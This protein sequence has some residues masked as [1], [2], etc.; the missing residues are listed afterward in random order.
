M[1]S[2]QL[3]GETDRVVIAQCTDS[4]RDE[5]APAGD[6]YDESAYFRRQR[7]YAQVRGDLWFIQSAKHGL[8]D[9]DKEIAPYDKHAKDID[10]PE[11][12]AESIA[13][14][15]QKRVPPGAVVEILGGKDYADPLTPELERRGYDVHEPLRGLGIGKR[16]SELK[17]RTQEVSHE[18][19]HG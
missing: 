19:L 18:S 4:K 3:E 13:D 5:P 16:Q 6:I 12:W 15:L 10:K 17:T 11:S 1:D 8:L 2:D 14:K 9:P 7:E